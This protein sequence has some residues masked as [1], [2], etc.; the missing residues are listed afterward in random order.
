MFLTLKMFKCWNVVIALVLMSGV[1]F[2]FP[3]FAQEQGGGKEQ[4]TQK[5]ETKKGDEKP[6]FKK[7]TLFVGKEH[8]KDIRLPKMVIATDGTLIAFTGACRIYRRSE[9]KGE[10]WSDIQ[11]ISP[12]CGGANVVVDQITGDILVLDQSKRGFWRSQDHAKTWA[13]EKAEFRPNRAGQGVLGK[14]PFGTAGS[15]TG[16]TLMRGKYKGRLIIPAR[17]TPLAE[18][19]KKDYEG[20]P[21]HYNSVIYSDDRGKTWQSGEPVQ[22]G[23][24]EAA[25]AELSDGSIY[26]NSR[27]HM[28]CDN[29]RRIAWSYDGGA[30]FADWSASD[31]L[32][33]PSGTRPNF[34][35]ARKPSYGTSAG[36]ARM[37]DGTTEYDDVLLF[38]IAD[39]KERG[40]GGDSTKIV[41]MASFDR[42]ETW[43]VE[44]NIPHGGEA[45][46]SSLTADDDGMIYLLFEKSDPPTRFTVTHVSFAKF[47][48][49]WL[50]EGNPPDWNKE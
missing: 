48:L 44:R 43:P 32:F 36:L 30:N 34:R 39:T 27:A 21:Y 18:P 47:N 7:Q 37:P 35:Y 22:T 45:I 50:K 9:D 24:G 13:F 15:E 4:D 12:D 49:A 3:S 28:S 16:I 42:E 6:F 17:F 23:T 26:I 5:Q 11:R 41:V 25:V 20:W 40:K 29:R 2:S 14:T 19:G 31:E 10:T 38:S 8:P 1:L 46:Y 33:E